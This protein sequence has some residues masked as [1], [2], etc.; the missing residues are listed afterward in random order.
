MTP[1]KNIIRKPTD[2]LPDGTLLDVSS[3]GPDF[4]P[5]ESRFIAWFT[6][7]G[8]EAFL[9]A[10]RAAVRAGYNPANAVMQGYLLKQ[11]PRIAEAI[12]N[13]LQSVKDNLTSTIWRIWDLAR[14]R[15]FYDFAD[16]YRTFPYK[17]IIHIGKRQTVEFDT[18]DFEAIPI[19]ELS[20]NKRMCIDGIDYKGP[21]EKLIYKLPNRYKAYKTFT[22]CSVLLFPDLFETDPFL[23]DMATVF[24]VKIKKGFKGVAAYLRGE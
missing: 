17:Q 7:P 13:T 5:R 4:T 2:T 18:W 24:K 20:W 9:N 8:T 16:F 11:K 1:K 3:C 12:K 21:E 19:S 15:M 10:G 22:E 23:R 14:I 6:H